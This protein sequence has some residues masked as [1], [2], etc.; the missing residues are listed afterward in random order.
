MPLKRLVFEQYSFSGL[1][2]FY[3]KEGFE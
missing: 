3:K 1:A 2:A